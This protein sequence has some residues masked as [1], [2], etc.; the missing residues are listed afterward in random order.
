[1]FAATIT[2]SFL[3]IV[4]LISKIFTNNLYSPIRIFCIWWAVCLGMS[5]Y[6]VWGRNVASNTIYLSILASMISFIIGAVLGKKKYVFGNY[7]PKEDVLVGSLPNIHPPKVLFILNCIS[8]VLNIWLFFRC[9]SLIGVSMFTDIGS[10][11]SSIYVSDTILRS[12]IDIYLHSYLLR[13]TLYTIVIMFPSVFSKKEH[14]KAMFFSLVNVLFYTFIYGGRMF[15]FY[16]SILL[17]IGLGLR[18]LLENNNIKSKKLFV[19]HR[20]KDK[21]F[22]MYIMIAIM[23]IVVVALTFSRNNSSHE[24][25]IQY[26]IEKSITYFS[27]APA[28]YEYLQNST[29]VSEQSG[30]L[31]TFIGGLITFFSRINGIIGYKLIPDVVSI[32]SSHLTSNLVNVGGSVYTNAFPTMV[33]TFRFDFNYFGIVFNS[34]IFGFISEKIYKKVRIFRNSKYYYL[35]LVV[36]YFIIESPMRWSGQQFWPVFVVCTILLT[37]KD[38]RLNNN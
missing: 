18:N 32:A 12:S 5:L 16:M 19:I 21:K 7:F 27:S 36:L 2:I 35:Y 24:N 33:Y 1:M 25:G 17:V 26:F 34:M 3:V 38:G 9:F 37:T 28:Y 20:S 10:A 22:G 4:Y 13:G 6:P 23:A 8:L 30:F 15:L 14:K 31:F 29:H 11:R